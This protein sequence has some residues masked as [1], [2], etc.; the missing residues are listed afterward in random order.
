M[1]TKLIVAWSFTMLNL[2]IGFVLLLG[3][4]ESFTFTKF[5]V[6]KVIALVALYIA[7]EM[8]KMFKNNEIN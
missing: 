4:L 5:I 7:F 8:I 1:K 2:I 6:I 3:K